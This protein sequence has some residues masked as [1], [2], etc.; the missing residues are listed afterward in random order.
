MNIFSGTSALAILGNGASSTDSLLVNYFNAQRQGAAAQSAQTASQTTSRAQDKVSVPPWDPSKNTETDQQKLND[1]KATT[2]FV[3]KNGNYF[4]NVDTPADIKKLYTAYQALAKLDALAKS[5]AADGTLSGARPGL[6]KVFQKGLAEFRDYLS[7]LSFDKLTLIEGQK[8]P[9]AKST[10]AVPRMVASQYTG[11]VVVNGAYDTPIALTG[12]QTFTVEVKKNGAI[13]DVPIDLS[14]LGGSATLDN[15]ASYINSA[16]ESAGVVS[17]VARNQIDTDKF[18]LVV[19]GTETE[20]LSFVA[21][22]GTPAVYVAGTSGAS[23]S[24]AGHFLRFN[25]DGTGASLDFGKRI[26][27]VA[28]FVTTPTTTKDSSTATTT[29]TDVATNVLAPATAKATAVDADGHVY[30]VGTSQGTLNGK[31]I[32]GAQDVYLSKYDSTG[33]VIWSR[34]LGATSHAD[35]FAVATDSKGNVVI[36][37][38]ADAPLTQTAVGGGKDSFVSKFNSEGEEIFTRQTD[39]VADDG[40]TSLSIGPD[41]SIYVGGYAKSAISATSTYAGQ[42]DAT[43]TKLSSTGTRLYTREFGT[44]ASDTTR[45][46]AIASDGNLLVASVENDH[47]ILRKFDSSTGATDALWSLDL[48]ALQGGDIGA[49]AVDGNSIYVGGSSSNPALDGGG[50][51]AI[52]NPQSGGKDGFVARISDGGSSAA[53]DYVTYIGTGSSDSIR[54]L[55]ATNGAVYVT[56]ETEGTLPGQTKAGSTNGF[57]AKLDSSG[58]LAWTQQYGGQGGVAAGASIAVAAHGASVLDQLGLPTGTFDFSTSQRLTANSTLRAGDSFAVSVN[59]K[60]SRS[61]TIAADDTIQSLKTRLNAILLQAGKASS[62]Y[63]K[64]GYQL[65]ITTNPGN[66]VEFIAGK[67]GFDALKGLGI[68]AGSIVNEQNTSNTDSPQ[69]TIT[70]DQLTP[71]NNFVALGLDRSISLAVKSDADKALTQIESAM[72]NIRLGYTTLTEGKFIAGTGKYAHVANTG[73]APAYLQSQI[74]NY[75]DALA[76]L[77]G[78]SG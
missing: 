8:L 5:A 73:A 40:A 11:Q 21:P 67:E 27:A 50:T 2:N 43:V 18:G 22:N 57:V 45:S 34:L 4:N 69:K 6:D 32:E 42:G 9:T 14:L 61:I 39:P 7:G 77:Q 38:N 33:T 75:K 68:R 59:G 76:R 51:A 35:G 66:S 78:S 3:T 12:D 48:G 63:S 71:K 16:L 15:I 1:A 25:D 64:N 37:G 58:A 74:A 29:T 72:R 10:L 52:L 17:R 55:A 24:I 44:A 46:L 28:K 70:P 20:T 60:P 41:D 19:N 36:A 13:T 54:G 65:Q 31:A 49:I 56:G 30:V 53:Q 47:A 23:N 62:V 26:E